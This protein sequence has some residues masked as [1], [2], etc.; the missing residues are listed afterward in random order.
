MAERGVR[1]PQGHGRDHVRRCRGHRGGPYA[2]VR[3]GGDRGA[4]AAVGTGRGGG[5]PDPGAAVSRRSRRRRCAPDRRPGC[6]RSG[7]GSRSG[8]GP[9]S[10]WPSCGRWMT[11][12][13]WPGSGSAR[14]PPGGRPAGP[15]SPR[16]GGDGGAWLDGTAARAMA[17]DAILTPVVTGDVD[18]GMLDDLVRLCVELD[19]LDHAADRPRPPDDRQPDQARPHR[20]GRRCGRRSSARPPTCC[21]VPAGWPASCGPGSSA[22]GSP[23]QPAAGHRVQQGHP[24]RDP[25]RRDPAGPALPVARRLPPARGRLPGA[26]RH[27]PGARRRH[28]P[29]RLCPSVFIPSPDRDPPVGLDPGTNPD[30]TTT[31]WNPDRTKVLHSHGPPARAG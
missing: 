20:P 26:S 17:C 29:H 10:R 18:P 6:C 27:A 12:R 31:A 8:S 21:P 9:M 2:G 16:R 4:G 30:G 3:G 23:A 28:Q 5:H 1:G 7:P 15:R 25:Q 24:A 19:R 22:P 14:W 11:G 13:C